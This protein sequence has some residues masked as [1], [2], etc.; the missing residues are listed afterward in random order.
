MV[1]VPVYD[2]FQ[3]APDVRRGRADSPLS[4][5]QA[6]APGEQIQ[7]LGQ[8]IQ[9]GASVA[10]DFFAKEQEKANKVILND[11]FNQASAAA[12]RLKYD[13][14]LGY[15]RLKGGAAVKGVNDKPLGAYYGEQFD[16][17]LS[18]ITNKLGNQAVREQFGMLA[19]DLRAKFGNETMAY[20]AEQS[21]VYAQSV[22]E[23][24]IVQSQSDIASDPLG[25][26]APFY[27]SRARD[28][29]TATA[30]AAGLDGESLDVAVKATMGKMHTGVIETMMDGKNI[31]GAKAY[32]AAHETDYNAI[33]AKAIKAKL[34]TAFS[35]AEAIGAVDEVLAKNPLRTNAP[36]NKAKIDSELR[37]KYADQPE[38]L[39]AARAELSQRI[40]DHEF[41]ETEQNAGNVNAVWKQLLGGQSL[42]SVE[43][44]SA[45]LSLPG[46][47]QASLKSTF[48]S[49]AESGATV[50]DAAW[51][52]WGALMNDD[53]QVRKMTPTQITALEPF[54][55]RALTNQVLTRKRQLTEE[56]EKAGLAA[57]KIDNDLFQSIAADF[58]L[59][60]YSDDLD[61]AD[62][63]KLARL[64]SA[65][66]TGVAKQQAA[67]GKIIPPAEMDAFVR[68]NAAQFVS[69][70]DRKQTADFMRG[71]GIAP[72]VPTTSPDGQRALTY[73][74][75][76]G[77]E[78]TPENY[79]RAL[80]DVFEA[81]DYLVDE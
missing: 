4:V 60:V 73:M 2:Q 14:D 44:T 7:Q 1:Q 58:G 8:G 25:K 66:E 18:E 32:F 54:Y 37:A 78:A 3:V 31:A 13:K 17:D 43:G 9:K 29:A 39:K 23:A 81:G 80:V 11:A 30:Q 12:Q 57:G 62:R 68:R 76:Q 59:K 33:D 77:W 6:R 55:G 41:Q 34:D 70:Y 27:T 69:G 38:Q 74:Q 67:T 15:T 48:L 79:R 63:V 36:V 21:V 24:T 19:A 42:A 20:E 5:A 56:Q 49:R 61:N 72:S 22:R 45:W 75:E 40:Q 50:S 28:A 53:E 52:A 47:T 26:A 71:R 16:K 65:L 10:A 46:D 35:A 51:A 64:R